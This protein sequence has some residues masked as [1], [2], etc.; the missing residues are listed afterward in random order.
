L[1]EVLLSCASVQGSHVG[2]S[3]LLVVL[4]L[5]LNALVVFAVLALVAGLGFATTTGGL[6]TLLLVAAVG[7]VVGVVAGVIVAAEGLAAAHHFV[8]DLVDGA[9]KEFLHLLLLFGLAFSLQIDFANPEL[10]V[11]GL[12]VGERS[13]FVQNSDCLLA[14][15]NSLVE[16]VSMVKS[17]GILNLELDADNVSVLA[18]QLV[19]IIVTDVGWNK[20]DEQIAGEILVDVLVNSGLCLVSREFIL[21]LGNMVVHKQVNAFGHLGLVHLLNGGVG[22]SGHLVADVNAVLECVIRVILVENEGGNFTKVSEHFA[23]CCL[24]STLCEALNKDVVTLSRLVGC[25]ISIF[26]ALNV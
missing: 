10:N 21:A 23:Q 25:V 7:V 6:G 18:E 11:N 26:C 14:H 16:N 12:V 15:F 5:A 22:S 3:H 24:I 9:A 8:L 2:C 4:V 13:R 1:D 20:L 17:A 19:K